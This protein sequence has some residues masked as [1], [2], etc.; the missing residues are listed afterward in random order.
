M[1]AGLYRSFRYPYYIMQVRKVA[2]IEA[3]RK[4]QQI[5]HNLRLA[6]GPSVD[7]AAGLVEGFSASDAKLDT[8]VKDCVINREHLLKECHWAEGVCLFAIGVAMVSLVWLALS[9]F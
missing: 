4:H 8:V 1:L 5:K 7:M 3:E 6:T 2:W 9:T